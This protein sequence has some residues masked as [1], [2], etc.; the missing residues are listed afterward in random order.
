MHD[1]DF[2]SLND[3]EFEICSID[4]L[5][6]KLATRIE[7]FKPGKDRGIDG[8]FFSSADGEVLIQCKHW[9]RATF[10]ALL[11]SLKKSEAPKAKKLQ[12]K[13]YILVV[14][15]ELSRENKKQIASTFHPILAESDIF[16]REDLN[17][18]LR[19]FPEIETRHYKL[20]LSS[21]TALRNII[22]SGVRGRSEFTLQQIIDRSSVYVPTQAQNS[23]IKVLED[24][25]SAI[26]IGP[27]GAGKTTLA[28]HICLEYIRND[29]HFYQ[30]HSIEEAEDH[31]SRLERQVFY[32]DDFLGSN[33]LRALEGRADAK[34]VDF[35]RRIR[36]DKSKRFI[37]TSRTNILN[38]GRQLSTALQSTA[39]ASG[40]IEIRT[41]LLTK[42]EKA[43]ILYNHMFT[44][45]LRPEYA[46]EIVA[47][48][49]YLEIVNHS[50]YSPRLIDFITDM[51]RT[52]VAPTGYWRTILSTLKN[53]I[54][55]WRHLYE[56]QLD[57]HARLLVAL[58]SF[59]GGRI[60]ERN[61]ERAYNSALGFRPIAPTSNLPTT[62]GTSA[63]HITGSMLN[64]SIDIHQGNAIY[65]D[66]FDPS[67]ADFCL[68]EHATDGPYLK[69]LFAS[70]NTVQS[71]HTL[72]SLRGQH[73]INPAALQ[74]ILHRLA[75]RLTQADRYDIDYLVELAFLLTEEPGIGN[76]YTEGI[77][78]IVNHCIIALH[79][80]DIEKICNLIKWLPDNP[81][82]NSDDQSLMNYI[83]HL[84]TTVAGDR[85][86]RRLTSATD[87][88]GEK[89]RR[90]AQSAL[91]HAVVEYLK[92]TLRDHV[93]DNGILDEFVD[94][95]T[96]RR[97]VTGAG[98][99]LNMEIR[100]R[101]EECGISN[102]GHY[103]ESDI[104]HTIELS[105]LLDG[106][107]EGQ[108]QATE[109]PSRPMARPDDEDE[110]IRNLF[111]SGWWNDP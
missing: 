46:R 93:L 94:I 56:S 33:Y 22:N 96:E 24:H 63:R 69:V 97:D 10:K 49:R 5:S 62:F 58:V 99:R 82:R 59:N 78:K 26:I 54:E 34:I 64:R 76:N 8:R 45:A 4:L 71:L 103:A 25:G 38:R 13:R 79:E 104:L 110:A 6:Q 12:P 86:F 61:L 67:V 85:D 29:F 37:L 15:H 43:K 18:I 90:Q 77:A 28:Q 27:P 74:S 72:R 95:D 31:Y 107:E 40:Q 2:S 109:Y 30:I 53:P 66:V 83:L 60:F 16:G 52:R 70:L 48:Q 84:A 65:Y 68:R 81:E 7:R 1:Y 50:S 23:A 92:E 102:T 80:P 111:H 14:S 75:K 3:K 35:I 19:L 20:W 44:R 51:T 42:L 57:E 87:R 11:N 32:F 89:I 39:I 105:D 101:L 108:K 88:L 55:I 36:Q 100:R 47:N 73:I 21:T 91:E 17:D 9:P 106:V 41:D 98:N